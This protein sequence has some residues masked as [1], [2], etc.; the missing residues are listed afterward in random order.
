[1]KYLT[2][3][4]LGELSQFDTPTVCNALEKFGLRKKTEGFTSPAVRSIFGSSVPLVGY[5]CTAK[6]SATEPGSAKN[7]ELLFDYYK[8]IKDC[9]APISVIEDLDSPSI[10]SFWGEVQTTV[11]LALGCKGTITGGGVR[12]LKEAEELGFTYIASD[13]LVSH[14]YIHV[15]EA[16]TPVTIAGLVIR[17]GD[18]LHADQHGAIIIPNEVAALTA[19][20]CRQMQ[21]AELPVLNGCRSVKAG[22]LSL[23]D[24]R[25]WR[26]EMNELRVK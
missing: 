5:A 9:P 13:V 26:K 24:L 10:G 12:D 11:H 18:L 16:G 19:D 15:E 8:S 7:E 14:A 23:E 1:M 6:V 17:P 21:Q 22:D 20:A 2:K 25:V 4:Q 3:E